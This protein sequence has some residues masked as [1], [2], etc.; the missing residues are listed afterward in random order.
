[1]K[2][3]YMAI[4]LCFFFVLFGCQNNLISTKQNTEYK[5]EIAKNISIMKEN[6]LFD[7]FLNSRN[8]ENDEETLKAIEFIN[9]T[10]AVLEE[11]R[12]EENGE[13][14]I[15]VIEA[16]FCGGSTDDFA[17]A[18]SK[19]DKQKAVDFSNVIK[20]FD[21]SPSSQSRSASS[22]QNN[23]IFEYYTPNLSRAIYSD[24][25]TWTSVGIYTGFCASTV[26]GFVLMSCGGIWT[27]PIGLVA[28]AAGSIS[29]GIQLYKW[30][31]SSDLISFTSSIVNMDA[32]AANKILDTEDG[33]KLLTVLS[34]TA[35]T[36]AVCSVTTTGQSLITTVKS[37]YNSLVELIIAKLPPN[38][39]ISIFGI[40]IE[41]I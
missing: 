27:R 23:I 24:K 18:L 11:I 22:T 31:A 6:G 21:T 29:M 17:N 34:E 8:I 32:K 35:I 15:K 5:T 40:P 41:K 37:G 12:L 16:L 3:K 28:A 25:L 10:D 4:S 7:S 33:K 38:V 36:V 14:Q 13:A 9:N 19:I 30:S 2:S 39:K 26:A 1:M 20:E